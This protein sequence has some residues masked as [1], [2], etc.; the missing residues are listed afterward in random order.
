ME[1]RIKLLDNE[2]TKM[3]RKIDLA[4]RQAE[5]VAF[6][7][8]SQEEKFQRIQEYDKLNDLIQREKAMKVEKERIK[9]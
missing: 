7:Q 1:S 2:E 5:K 6:A 9:R 3:K 4:K 8:A